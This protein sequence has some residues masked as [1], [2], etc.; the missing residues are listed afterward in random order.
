MGG[1]RALEPHVLPL[2]ECAASKA[3]VSSNREGC[4]EDRFLKTNVGD[5]LSSMCGNQEGTELEIV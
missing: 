4:R 3:G 1:V 5:I 2:G